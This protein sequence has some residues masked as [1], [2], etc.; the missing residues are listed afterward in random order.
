MLRLKKIF[1]TLATI[2][3]IPLYSLSQDSIR[4]YSRP[5]REII[6][7]HNLERLWCLDELFYKDSLIALYGNKINSKDSLINLYKNS[8]E[9]ITNNNKLITERLNS[10]NKDIVKKKKKFRVL[11]ITI[12]V[13]TLLLLVLWQH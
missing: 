1:T 10:A 5:E 8:N 12:A 9:S 7:S 2:A 11:Y 3:L 4:C 13:E 6:A